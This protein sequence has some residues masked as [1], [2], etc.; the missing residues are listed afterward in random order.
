MGSIDG[1]V[2]TTHVTL[3]DIEISNVGHCMFIE[4]YIISYILLDSGAARPR[5]LL[6]V[7][8]SC[9]FGPIITRNYLIQARRAILSNGRTDAN[10]T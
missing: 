8:F 1:Y 6:L 3:D 10:L 9:E 4:L 2:F 5:C 7:N